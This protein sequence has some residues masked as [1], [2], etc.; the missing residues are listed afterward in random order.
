MKSPPAEQTVFIVDDEP[1]IR[2][3]L[4]WLIELL[5]VPVR[6]FPSAASYLDA[7]Q[8]STRAA[9]FLISGCPA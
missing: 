3:S 4:Q 7:Y 1:A 9:S 6:T 2:K 8:P 5:D